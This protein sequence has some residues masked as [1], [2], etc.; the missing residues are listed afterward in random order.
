ML[1]VKHK[2]WN[3]KS[4]HPVKKLRNKILLKLHILQQHTWS[5]GQ[6]RVHTGVRQKLVLNQWNTAIRWSCMDIFVFKCCRRMGFCKRLKMQLSALL[7]QTPPLGAQERE[8]RQWSVILKGYLNP[9]VD[10]WLFDAFGF[11]QKFKISSGCDSV[12]F[13]SFSISSLKG[14]Y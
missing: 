5:E 12:Q 3:A 1:R 6:Y 11:R 9:R 8:S 14:L 13:G 10:R 7:L 4:L 2:L